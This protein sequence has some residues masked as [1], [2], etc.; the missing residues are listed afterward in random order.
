MN[1][2][3]KLTILVDVLLLGLSKRSAWPRCRCREIKQAIYLQSLGSP[4]RTDERFGDWRYWTPP[5]PCSAHG[6]T[7]RIRSLLFQTKG[8]NKFPHALRD[9]GRIGTWQGFRETEGV[10][11]GGLQMQNPFSLRARISKLLNSRHREGSYT[12]PK[13]VITKN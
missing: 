12:A 9:C 7:S 13:L 3:R 1:I 5:V 11:R 4:G 10:L 2:I 6:V 8:L